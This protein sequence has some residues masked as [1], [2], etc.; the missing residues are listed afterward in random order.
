MPALREA[1][2]A[3]GFGEVRT[4]VQSGNV[5][6]SADQSGEELARRV[7][8]LIADEFGLDVAVIVRT[9]DQ[10]AKIVERNPLQAVATNPKRYQ[11][12]FLEKK[13]GRQMLE[14]LGAL[15]APEEQFVS[16]GREVYAWHPEGVARSKLWSAL[17]SQRGATARNWRTVTQLLAISSAT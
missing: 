9:R 12:T 3:G 4:Y 7:H 6:L 17:A 5:V 10:L 15:A 11:V 13:L 1:L 16:V 14:K 2:S 8:D